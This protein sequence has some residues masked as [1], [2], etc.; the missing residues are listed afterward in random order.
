MADELQLTVRASWDIGTPVGSLP[1]AFCDALGIDVAGSRMIYNIQN[2]GF[3][4]D[5]ALLKGDAGSGGYCI[6]RNL[7]TTNYVSVFAATGETECIR[8]LAGDVAVFRLQASAPYVQA[9]TG[10]VNLEYWLFMV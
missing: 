2:V 8:L 1:T 7:D 4:S 3:A 6:M 10:A 5:E 9:D